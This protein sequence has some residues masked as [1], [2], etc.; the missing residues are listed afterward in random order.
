MVKRLCASNRADGEPCMAAPL[1]D[2]DHCLLHSPEHAEEVAEARRLGGLRRR[3]EVAVSGAYDYRGIDSVYDIRRLIEIAVLDTLSID[4][5]LSRNRTL[6]YLAQVALK[7]LETGELEER[8]EALESAVQSQENRKS[9]FEADSDI[10]RFPSEE[11][12]S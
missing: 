4:N 12:G 5:S 9:I 10:V 11:I 3:R 7:A 6:A 1:R 8:I 2:G